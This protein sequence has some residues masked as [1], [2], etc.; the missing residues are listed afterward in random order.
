MSSVALRSPA[1]VLDP[2][3]LDSP[4][5]APASADGPRDLDE[6]SGLIGLLLSV[7][8]PQPSPM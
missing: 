6:L 4:D 1:L 3:T 2:P 7:E 5:A 8:A